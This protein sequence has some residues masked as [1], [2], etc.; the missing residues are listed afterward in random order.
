MMETGQSKRNMKDSGNMGLEGP[1]YAIAEVVVR[2]NIMELFEKDRRAYLRMVYDQLRSD[3]H[4]AQPQ[5]AATPL[6][7]DSDE[8]SQAGEEGLG[9]G[10]G[11]GGVRLEVG[12]HAGRSQPARK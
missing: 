8:Q 12:I 6:I 10:L 7:Y 3:I 9:R 4:A 11:A 2:S 1:H 5:R